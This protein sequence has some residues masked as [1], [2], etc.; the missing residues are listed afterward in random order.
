MALYIFIFDAE[1]DGAAS[2][3]GQGT[4]HVLAT[5]IV[6][7]A[8]PASAEARARDCVAASGHAVTRLAVTHGPMPKVIWGLSDGARRQIHEAETRGIGMRFMGLP[9]ASSRNA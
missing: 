7:A 2:S 9:K 4:D 5:V 6:K 1:P 3:Q 8:E